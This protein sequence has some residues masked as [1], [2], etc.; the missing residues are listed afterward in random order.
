MSSFILP[1][2]KKRAK[3]LGAESIFAC[4]GQVIDVDWALDLRVVDTGRRHLLGRQ[5][6][7][8]V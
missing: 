7:T 1:Q 6:Y 5:A 4:A 2:K 3:S 8:S